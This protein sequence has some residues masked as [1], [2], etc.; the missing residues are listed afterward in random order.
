LF[1]AAAPGP[2]R[3]L[4]GLREGRFVCAERGHR[5]PRICTS[6]R[7]PPGPGAPAFLPSLPDR[8][9]LFGPRGGKRGARGASCHHRLGALLGR[10]P[11]R[12][13][14]LNWVSLSQEDSA[15]C[16][17]RA[18]WAAPGSVWGEDGE[19]TRCVCVW[20]GRAARPSSKRPEENASHLGEKPG[21]V[22]SLNNGCK[23]G[24]Q[25]SKF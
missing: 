22:P 2:G 25:T 12:P 1:A 4:R 11:T 7:V 6:P 18:K 10:G 16:C 9:P 14:T 24:T 15:L 19:S 5:W 23:R 20:G 17:T 21:T 3:G 13:P 8:K